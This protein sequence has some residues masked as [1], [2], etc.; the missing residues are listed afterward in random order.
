M[1]TP[2]EYPKHKYHKTK[3]S[4]IVHTEQQEKELG[5]G[6]E[7]HPDK[8]KE[9]EPESAAA[10]ASSG[11]LSADEVSGNV[12]STGAESSTIASEETSGKP[13]KGK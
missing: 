13:R 11:L 5:E 1:Y 12:Q 2:V 8:L 9:D 4:Q 3:G 7:D 6:W 10:P